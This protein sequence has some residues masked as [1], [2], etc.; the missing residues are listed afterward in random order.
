M[1]KTNDAIATRRC[2]NC[3]ETLPMEDF[4]FH[5]GMPQGKAYTC[6]ACNK[7][8]ST[9]KSMKSRGAKRL[10]E[11]IEHDQKLISLKQRAILELEDE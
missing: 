1:S 3:H 6:K 4:Y 10:Q 5:R 7:L 9:I 2:A 8:S 11:E